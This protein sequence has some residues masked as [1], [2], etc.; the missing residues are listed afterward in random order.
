MKT[1]YLALEV[2]EGDWQRA[3]DELY[4][5]DSALTRRLEMVLS[6]RFPAIVQPVR[7][8]V[9]LK[10]ADAVTSRRALQLAAEMAELDGGTGAV[11][12]NAMGMAELQQAFG[13]IDGCLE[14]ISRHGG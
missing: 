10:I 1:I 2:P 5:S 6:A 13:A 3:T 8:A 4:V 11:L 9:M 12:E 14:V 7:N